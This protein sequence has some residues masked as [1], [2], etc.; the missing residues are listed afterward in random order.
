MFC[1]WEDSKLLGG[2]GTFQG[3]VQRKLRLQF[4][5]NPLPSRLT[6][7]MSSQGGGTAEQTRIYRF[8]VE[9]NSLVELDEC[10]IVYKCHRKAVTAH[11]H[12]P[13]FFTFG[14]F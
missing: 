7:G 9:L 5:P 3:E 10:Q 6:L 12:I 2:D 13:S 8:K 11:G 4:I 14:V 1:P